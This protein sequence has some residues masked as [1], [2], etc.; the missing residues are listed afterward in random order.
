MEG[1]FKTFNKSTDEL[2]LSATQKDVDEAFEKEKVFLLE[3][4]TAI[5]DAA[6]K[7]DKMAKAHKRQYNK[8][9]IFILQF[10]FLQF[11]YFIVSIIKKIFLFYNFF[12]L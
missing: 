6:N 4:H 8:K 2:L 5:K 9:K 11:F 10:F 12:I 1:L 3:Y 7:A